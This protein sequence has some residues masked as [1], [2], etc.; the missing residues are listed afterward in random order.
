MRMLLILSLV[1]MLACFSS[2]YAEAGVV[3]GHGNSPCSS[4]EKGNPLTEAVFAWQLG[5]LTGT[6]GAYQI[7]YE[8]LPSSDPNKAKKV[9]K[10]LRAGTNLS[11]LTPDTIKAFNKNYCMSHPE[12]TVVEVSDGLAAY[13]ISGQEN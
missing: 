9:E 1:S 2:F 6:L 8:N 3:K 11:I 10:L 5:Y 4:F 13:L 12:A 7:E